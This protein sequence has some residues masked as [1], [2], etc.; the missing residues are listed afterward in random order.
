MPGSRTLGAAATGRN[1]ESPRQEGQFMDSDRTGIDE[2]DGKAPTGRVQALE[3]AI[4]LL[5][6]VAAASPEGDS[7]ANLAIDC[8]LNRATA[9]R[10]LSTLEH[11][12]L[13]ERDPRTGQ[14]AVGFAVTRM[15]ARAGVGGLV[16][17][18]HHIVRRLSEE[19]GETAN[20]AVVQ[21]LG[22]TYVDEVIP[23]V[24]LSA[25]W[26]GRAAPPHATSAGKA[27]LAWLPEPEAD[28]MLTDPLTAHSATTITDR[29]RLREEFETIRRDGYAV[30]V[31][32][33]ER[34][35]YGVSAPVFDRHGQPFAVIGLWGPQ[36]RVPETRFATL[37]ALL[38]TA[39]GDISRE[40]DT[41]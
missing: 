20:L 5:N 40:A 34:S 23:S 6:A 18:T 14:Y 41:P 3:R 15:A 33:M 16:R 32:E 25:R 31:G 4:G 9:W 22:L 19:T 24:V 39:A 17:R 8:G 10:L 12:A 1:G 11:H 35:L 21:N 36:D 29:T 7:A 37:G 38:R 26:L 13:V 30:S 2:H 27:L 28:S